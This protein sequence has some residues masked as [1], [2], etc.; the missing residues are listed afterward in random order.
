MLE[1]ILCIVIGYLF[2]C[3]QTAYIIGKLFYKI[4]IRNYGSGNPGATNAMRVL[5]TGTG[6]L[7]MAIDILKG[8]FAIIVVALMYGYDMK[9]LLLWT[10]IGT[11]LGHNFPFYLGFKG[12]KG[13]AST[14]GVFAAVDIRILFFAG[15]PALIL[16]YA[17]RYMSLASL[18]YMTLMP[19]VTVLLYITTPIGVEVLLLTLFF[20]VSAY[21]RHRTNIVRLVHGTENKIGQHS[22]KAA[23]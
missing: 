12:G 14:L 23:G 11:I 18:T 22:K 16:L 17:T 13:V 20:T 7:T 9:N 3:V 8:V 6:M 4:D 21:W 2:G 15:I 10:G 5:G 19:I 1:R